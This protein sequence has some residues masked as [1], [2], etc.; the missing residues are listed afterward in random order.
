MSY[1][2]ESSDGCFFQDTAVT[3][4]NFQF[5]KNDKVVGSKHFI[6]ALHNIYTAGSNMFP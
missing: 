4:Y 2:R 6:I 3:E 5:K 1:P